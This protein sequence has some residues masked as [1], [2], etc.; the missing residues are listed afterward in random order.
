MT[1]IV[2]A[3]NSLVVVGRMLVEGDLSTA[4]DLAKQ[5]PILPLVVRAA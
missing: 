3:D 4:Y 2:S 1:K 5:I